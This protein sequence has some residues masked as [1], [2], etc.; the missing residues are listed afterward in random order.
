MDVETL[1]DKF[2]SITDEKYSA[3]IKLI[4]G[5]VRDYPTLDLNDTNLYFDELRKNIKSDS[6]TP[7][8]LENAMIESSDKGN[9]NNIWSASFIVH[10]KTVKT[11]PQYLTVFCRFLLKLTCF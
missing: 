1:E 11:P 4:I 8:S 2:E 9:E 10:K 6:I 7:D 5:A 3:I